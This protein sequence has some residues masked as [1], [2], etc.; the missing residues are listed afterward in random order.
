LLG[1]YGFSNTI[2]NSVRLCDAGGITVSSVEESKRGEKGEGRKR[3]YGRRKK[4]GEK[5]G[6]EGMG[7]EKGEERGRQ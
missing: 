6:R 2:R 4:I 3:E 1:D 5:E 7:G